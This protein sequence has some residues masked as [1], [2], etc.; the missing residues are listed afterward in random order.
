MKNKR[1]ESGIEIFDIS[2]YIVA[3]KASKE[4][5]IGIRSPIC[6]KN[7]IEEEEK[8]YKTLWVC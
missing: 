1:W 3:L 7:I 4:F 8:N 2:K 6:R 5:A